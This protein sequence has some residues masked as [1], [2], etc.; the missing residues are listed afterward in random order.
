MGHSTLDSGMSALP[1][2]R[3]WIESTNT[4]CAAQLKERR[5]RGDPDSADQPVEGVLGRGCG[6]VQVSCSG[7]LTTEERELI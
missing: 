7:T 1:T 6:G 3:I 4:E 2:C 5:P